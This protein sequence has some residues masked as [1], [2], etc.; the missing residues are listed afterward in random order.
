MLVTEKRRV[1][2]QKVV[3]AA[4]GRCKFETVLRGGS[5]IQVAITS[6][7]ILEKVREN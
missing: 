1:L 3:H 5:L 6:D 2:M 7:L 4:P